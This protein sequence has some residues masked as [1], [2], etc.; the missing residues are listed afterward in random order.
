MSA[1][2]GAASAVVVAMENR[3]RDPQTVR[4][5]PGFK[6]RRKWRW[7]KARKSAREETR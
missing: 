3:A 1:V 2:T 7:R 6:P 4:V 5:L